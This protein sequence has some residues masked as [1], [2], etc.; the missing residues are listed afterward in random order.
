MSVDTERPCRSDSPNSPA[1]RCRQSARIARRTAGQAEVA[2]QPGAILD[3]RVL[4]DH[5][6][7]RIAGEVEQTE[8]DE[9]H[10]AH[11]GGGLQDAAENEGEQASLRWPRRLR[12]APQAA[13][14]QCAAG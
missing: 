10:H 2:A 3:R 7:D 4:P 11:H 13:L 6:G 12:Q 1:P 14:A 5:E 8:G 9:R